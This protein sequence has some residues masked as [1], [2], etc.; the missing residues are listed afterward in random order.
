MT[1]SIKCGRALMALALASVA[2]PSVAGEITGSGKVIDINSS[3]VCAF[4]GYNDTP[5]GQFEPG[6]PEYDPGGVAQSFGY[7]GGYW[8]LWDAEDLD[9]R[10]V[11]LS[12]GFACNPNRGPNLKG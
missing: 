6:H 11:F 8:D 9:P 10:E 4:S 3:S 12:P 7:F 5:D 2:T 1:K